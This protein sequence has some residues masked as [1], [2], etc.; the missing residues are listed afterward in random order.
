MTF[1]DV[2]GDR[3]YGESCCQQMFDEKMFLTSFGVCYSTKREIFESF[4]FQFSS[5]KI[6]LTP[7]HISY[8]YPGDLNVFCHYNLNAI[9]SMLL[10]ELSM[11]FKG[12]KAVYESG[13]FYAISS[14][15]EHPAAVV[16]KQV[17]MAK[18]GTMENLSFNIHQ[19]PFC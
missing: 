15:D 7:R 12:T 14:K 16:E 1:C 6:W 5:I 10:S 3:L 17:H 19:V 8:R 11:K 9:P 4:P 2:K 18:A 13:I